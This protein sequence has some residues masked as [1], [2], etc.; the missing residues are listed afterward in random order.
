MRSRLGK[1]DSG[2]ARVCRPISLTFT[3]RHAVPYRFAR[4]VRIAGCD[5]SVTNVAI[6]ASNS[7]TVA[8][9][10]RGSTGA[11]VGELD[12]QFAAWSR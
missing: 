6:G 3:L 2:L 12:Y 8:R 1:E 5:G 10:A 4:A 9:H 7:K 11:V